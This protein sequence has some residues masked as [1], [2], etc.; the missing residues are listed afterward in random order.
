[1]RIELSLERE[2][3][4]EGWGALRNRF[5]SMFFQVSILD[6]L[7]SATKCLQVTFLSNFGC[8]S[9]SLGGVD[10]LTFSS[11][12]ELWA[13]LGPKC[14]QELPQEP[15]E[16]PQASTFTNFGELF[17]QILVICQHPKCRR[18]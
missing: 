13:V 15:P 12:F 5:F 14:L 2:L 1:M 11:F 9:G 6:M 10:E 7:F 3:D 16:P 18:A 17:G 4:P 8:P